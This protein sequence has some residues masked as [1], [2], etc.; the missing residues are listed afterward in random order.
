MV[1]G[2]KRNA[3]LERPPIFARLSRLSFLQPHDPHHAARRDFDDAAY[4]QS[5][6]ADKHGRPGEGFDAVVVVD[7]AADRQA[8]LR[9]AGLEVGVVD[10]AAVG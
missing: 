1:L 5:L 7:R 2:K 10:P 3:N 6:V 4:P 9:P 8:G